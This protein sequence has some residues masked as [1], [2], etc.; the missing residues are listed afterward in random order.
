MGLGKFL[1]QAGQNCGV[2]VYFFLFG[3]VYSVFDYRFLVLF[4]D[5]T[6]QEIPVRVRL[7]S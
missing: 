4:R 1:S 2:Q 6:R 5:L 7:G 3:D